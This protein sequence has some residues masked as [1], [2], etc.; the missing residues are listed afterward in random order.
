MLH[1]TTFLQVPE[2]KSVGKE[3]KSQDP[4]KKKRKAKKVSPAFRTVF[5]L[6]IDAVMEETTERLR[7]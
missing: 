3:L 6:E 4:G 5:S 1:K 7:N 2:N